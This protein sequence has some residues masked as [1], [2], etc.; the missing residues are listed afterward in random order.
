MSKLKYLNVCAGAMGITAALIG[1]TIIF[2][3]ASKASLKS[4]IAGSCLTLGGIGIASASL[5]QF[6]V[7]SD[8][9]KILS[10][11]RKAMPKTCRGCRNFHGIKYQGVMLVCGIHPHG[12]ESEHCPDFEK[13]AQKGKR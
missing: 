2:K 9:D 11:R 1:G 6:Q 12:I 4:L 8:I 10:E 13:F 7:E 5:Y 3:G